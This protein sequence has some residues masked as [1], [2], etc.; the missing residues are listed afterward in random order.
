MAFTF[1]DG[2][3]AGEFLVSLAAGN[4]S[5]QNINIAQSAALKAGT[6]LGID[7][8][9]S[10]AVAGVATTAGNGDFVAASVTCTEDA[11]A[12]VFR[13]VCLTA[14]KALLFD[15]DGILI[16][17]YT[18]GDAYDAD[19]IAF[20]TEG[21]WAA[22]DSAT[23]TVTRTAGTGKHVAFDQDLLTGPQTAVGILLADADAST[24]ATTGVMIARDAE[25]DGALLT[26]PSDIT[27]DEKTAAIAQL[28]LLGIIVR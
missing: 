28:A 18:I 24:A 1:T 10:A 14:T 15:P 25:V 12:G 7:Q 3:R 4:R 9:A 17:H 2:V 26:W 13:L 23:I 11:K 19:G 20:D 8:V 21:T 16:A 22:G 6:V 5:L 27:S